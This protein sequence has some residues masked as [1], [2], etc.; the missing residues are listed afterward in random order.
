MIFTFCRQLRH[1]Q[2]LTRTMQCLIPIGQHILSPN[3]K[4]RSSTL[5]TIKLPSS[6]ITTASH[7]PSTHGISSSSPSSFHHRTTTIFPTPT[8]V[9]TPTPTPTSTRTPAS[10]VTNPTI[11]VLVGVLILVVTV[12]ILISTYNFIYLP[13][14]RHRHTDIDLQPIIPPST[15]TPTQSRPSIPDFINPPTLP[16][17]AH[18]RRVEQEEGE[19]EFWRRARDLMN[20][21]GFGIWRRGRRRRRRRRKKGVGWWY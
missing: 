15:S 21:R 10:T 20:G 12:I 3:S 16:E 19:N 18:V 2:I 6:T 7:S 14:K 11:W 17:A 4:T 5:I 9:Q 13:H 8:P 1:P